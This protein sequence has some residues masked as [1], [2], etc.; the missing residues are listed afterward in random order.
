MEPDAIRHRLRARVRHPHLDA[1]RPPAQPELHRQ[2]ERPGVVRQ[3]LRPARQLQRHL[4]ARVRLPPRLDER[5]V[6]REP[7][8]LQR[9]LLA[10]VGPGVALQ[11]PGRRKQHRVASPD[12]LGAIQQRRLIQE[13]H[14]PGADAEARRQRPVALLVRK[15]V[16]VVVDDDD[17]VGAPERLLGPVRVLRGALARPEAPALVVVAIAIDR[18]DVRGRRRAVVAVAH[19]ELGAIGRPRPGH[20][21]VAAIGLGEMIQYP[22]TKPIYKVATGEVIGHAQVLVK[23]RCGDSLCF[24]TSVILTDGRSREFDS[25]YRCTKGK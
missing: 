23:F 3:R 9:P 22:E 19:D 12:V 13:E 20:G 8:L 17:V 4:R 25:D 5:Q 2:S 6:A 18:V 15:H 10:R 11:L 7:V 14:I 16:D 1:Q 24:K 21:A